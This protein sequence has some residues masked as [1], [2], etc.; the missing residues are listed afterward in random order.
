M[1][2]DN[3]IYPRRFWIGITVPHAIDLSIRT[4]QN[5]LR[6]VAVIHKC[7]RSEREGDLTFQVNGAAS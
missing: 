7:L 6:T 5:V 3:A 1:V 2:S 4:V